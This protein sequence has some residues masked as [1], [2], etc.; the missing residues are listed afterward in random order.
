MELV[1]HVIMFILPFLLMA[2]HPY[3]YLFLFTLSRAV[4][5]TDQPVSAT[6]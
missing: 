3:D 5:P 6:Q 1:S 2:A 4:F